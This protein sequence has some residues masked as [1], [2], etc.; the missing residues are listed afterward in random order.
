MNVTITTDEVTSLLGPTLP[1]TNPRPNF[2]NIRTLCRHIKRALQTLPCPQSIHLGWKGLIMSRGMYKLLTPTLFHQPNDPGPAAVYTRNDPTDTTP[3]MNTEQASID[4]AFTRKR[5]YYQL[6]INI[7]RACFIALNANIDDAFKSSDI[8]TILGWHASMETR[9]ILDQ[10]SQTYGQPTLAALEINDVTFCGPYSAPNAPEVLFRRIK[11]CTEIAILGNNPYT[12]WQLINNMIRLLLTTGLYIRAFEEWDHLLPGVQTWIKLRRLIQEVFQCCLN[13]TAPTV[14]GQGCAPA[15]HQNAFG[16]LGTNNSNDEE[17]LA[18]TVATQ[19]AALTY[20]SELTQTMAATTGQCQEMQLA[21]LAVAQEAQYATMHL[22]IE[23]LNAV[24]FYV[25]NAGHGFARFGGRGSSRGRYG[26]IGGQ[27]RGGGPP[28]GESLY[29]NGFTQGYYPMPM[30]HPINAPSSVT[31]Q[32]RGGTTFGVPQYNPPGTYATGG[33]PGSPQGGFPRGYPHAPTIPAQVQQ[34]PYSNVVKRYANW[35]ACYSC[36][37]DVADGHTS[38]L[39]PPHLRKAM[40]QIGFN[41]Q[42]AQQFID[43][44]H[45]CSTRNR[46][47]TQLPAPM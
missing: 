20:Q 25:S 44:S 9:D 29:S 34:Q 15:Y 45:P 27:Q 10:L 46:H 13:A 42:N 37:F 28:F 22:L 21:Q 33:F 24:A 19:V 40:H 31:G 4:T 23:G 2:E 47:K 3:L 5:H 7:E 1:S 36:G 11:N 41:C 14:G 35:N 16:I 43:S 30:A 38:M 26:R 12:D 39:C 6:L 18:N 17:S 32:F 8:P